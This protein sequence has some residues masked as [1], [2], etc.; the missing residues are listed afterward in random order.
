MKNVASNEK[1]ANKKARNS[2]TQCKI[3]KNKKKKKEVNV[4]LKISRNGGR[5][6]EEPRKRNKTVGGKWESLILLIT[7]KQL[8]GKLFFL[9]VF[10]RVVSSTI[11]L[12]GF[13]SFLFLWSMKG[14]PRWR[15]W[16]PMLQPPPFSDSRFLPS[17]ILALFLA[18]KFIYFSLP[19]GS[20]SLCWLLF[21]KLVS[22]CAI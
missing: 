12:R 21:Y 7:V 13:P 3:S 1:Y 15:K 17:A 4:T 19:F 14:G 2:S 18:L 6:A 8:G 5:R 9:S 20:S 16:Y 11:S 22:I 10:Q